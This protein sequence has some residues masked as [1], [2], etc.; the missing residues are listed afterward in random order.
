M[1][2]ETKQSILFWLD[3]FWHNLFVMFF[4]CIRKTGIQRSQQEEDTINSWQSSV[5]EIKWN[6]SGELKFKMGHD[7]NIIIVIWLV[8]TQQETTRYNFSVPLTDDESFQ[9]SF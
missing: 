8:R 5:Q 2:T 4:C 9:I 3:Q 1:Y 7:N 6:Y